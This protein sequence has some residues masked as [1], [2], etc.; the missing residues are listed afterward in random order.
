MS[1]N[2]GQYMT[3]GFHRSEAPKIISET[4]MLGKFRVF[5][6]KIWL[7][8]TAA[9]LCLTEQLTFDSEQ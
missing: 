7:S 8:Q 9:S 5:N 1:I 6:A 2:S 3:L 4:S